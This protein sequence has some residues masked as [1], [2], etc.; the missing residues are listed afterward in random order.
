[1]L[2]DAPHG[3]HP[4]ARRH[5]R[6]LRSTRQRALLWLSW[7]GKCAQCGDE[8]GEDWE[9]DHW[10]EPWRTSQRTNVH[11]MRPLCRKCNREK[12]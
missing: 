4:P 10:D 2:P 5:G 11:E 1:M 9:A 3:Q 6:T 12:G 8:L 7:N